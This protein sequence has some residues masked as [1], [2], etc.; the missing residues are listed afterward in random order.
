M[1]RPVTARLTGEVD[2]TV[3]YQPS[4][5]FPPGFYDALGRVTVA[6]GRLDYVMLIVLKRLHRT[7]EASEG[8]PR[9][10]F[11][12][13]LAE[14][15]WGCFGKKTALAAELFR[16]VV[17]DAEQVAAFET[18]LDRAAKIWDPGRNDNVHSYWT[19][20]H[21]GTPMRIRPK[22]IDKK[23]DWKRSAE[24]PV[25]DLQAIART[26]EELANEL[27]RATKAYL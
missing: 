18:C 5:A 7:V 8:K 11:D 22:L 14:N 4:D 12:E 15:Y 24:V 21:K 27:D 6:F 25:S 19:A 26:V 20:T 9:R 10:G 13:I 2:N 17:A 16:K 23:M 1:I 3:T